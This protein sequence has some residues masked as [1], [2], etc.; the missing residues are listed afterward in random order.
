MAST[1]PG[2]WWE[3]RMY[4]RSLEM[5]SPA[6]F[7]Y[8]IPLL[9]ATILQN[10]TTLV[11]TEE[12]IKPESGWFAQDGT[13]SKWQDQDSVWPT[14]YGVLLFR[15]RNKTQKW[16]NTGISFLSCCGGFH[17]FLSFSLHWLTILCSSITA[18]NFLLQLLCILGCNC[19]SQNLSPHA[20]N[21][22]ISEAAPTT[23][24]GPWLIQ[25]T[26]VHAPVIT[27]IFH[28]SYPKRRTILEC[29]LSNV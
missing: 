8:A 3:L 29:L 26:E 15:Q 10:I 12:G 2:A 14:F 18:V 1:V 4:I 19:S 17:S 13:I 27:A 6:A 24:K 16:S 23:S 20:Y 22:P 21:F 9:L 28:F 5:S 11:S 25:P 7:T